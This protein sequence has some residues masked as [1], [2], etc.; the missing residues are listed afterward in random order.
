MIP[1]IAYDTELK[2]SV[3]L[4][5]KKEELCPSQNYVEDHVIELDC[6]CIIR[7]TF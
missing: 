5:I 2:Q 3:Y 6:Y 4:T 7:M 1:N